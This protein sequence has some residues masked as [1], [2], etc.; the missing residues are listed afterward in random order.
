MQFAGGQR[1]GQ[2]TIGIAIYQNPIGF[3]EQHQ[4][5]ELLKHTAGVLT[6]STTTYAQIVSWPRNF[7]FIKKYI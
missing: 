3:F 2:S 5:F 7:E 1:T 4:F 6:M